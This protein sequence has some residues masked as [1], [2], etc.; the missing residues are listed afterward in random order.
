MTLDYMIQKKVPL[1]KGSNSFSSKDLINTSK[2][3]MKIIKYD[4]AMEEMTGMI[5]FL[6]SFMKTI[7][8]FFP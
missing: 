7:E 1:K 5:C 6:V 8:C 2:Y 4:D 3:G